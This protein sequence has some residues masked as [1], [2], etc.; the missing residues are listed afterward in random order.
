[1]KWP[2]GAALKACFA[3]GLIGCSGSAPPGD[4]VPSKG[5]LER[6]I[7]DGSDEFGIA[8]EQVN[9]HSGRVDTRKYIQYI[10]SN[11][12][13]KYLHTEGYMSLEEAIVAGSPAPKPPRAPSNG[14][15]LYAQS[16][17]NLRLEEKLN[18]YLVDEEG[19]NFGS[20]LMAEPAQQPGGQRIPNYPLTTEVADGFVAKFPMFE[21]KFEKVIRVQD[22]A[23]LSVTCDL[24]V[25]YTVTR[26]LTEFGKAAPSRIRSFKE[27]EEKTAC[28]AKYEDGWRLQKD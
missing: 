10:E 25:E 24:S 2:V 6:L 22:V 5:Q 28:L 12:L 19:S 21:T 7:V 9:V 3:L 14:Q 15:W 13:L 8:Y 27:A 1:M 4:A 16:V 18:K 17:S 11:D 26:A 20:N 23:D